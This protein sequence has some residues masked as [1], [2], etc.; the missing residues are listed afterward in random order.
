MM[1]KYKPHIKHRFDPWHLAKSVRKD[2]VAASKKKECANLVP[3]ISSIVN[4]LW[5][6]AAACD[7]D[8]QLCQKKWK[9]IVYHVAGWAWVT[10]CLSA[11]SVGRRTETKEGVASNWVNRT[12]C[13]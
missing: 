5:W 10:F 13:S 4:H 3:W 8:S 11:R 2:L 9:S 1:K 12:Q 7:G 6:S